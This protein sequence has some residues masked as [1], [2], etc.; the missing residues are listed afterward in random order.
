MPLREHALKPLTKSVLIPLELTGAASAA[1]AAI[2]KKIFGSGVT[3]IILNEEMNYIMKC[4]VKGL[5]ESGLLIKSICG[6]I[7]K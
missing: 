5:Q 4:L 3:K 7:E 1:A 2:H 6:R